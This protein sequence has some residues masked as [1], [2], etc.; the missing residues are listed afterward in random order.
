MKK[1]WRG[2]LISHI[3]RVIYHPANEASVPPFQVF[4]LKSPSRNCEYPAPGQASAGRSA[5]PLTFVGAPPTDGEENAPFATRH[6][7]SSL[8]GGGELTERRPKFRCAALLPTI[9]LPPASTFV[10]MTTLQRRLIAPALATTMNPGITNDSR[11][12]LKR[13]VP[14]T[15]NTYG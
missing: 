1:A 5:N 9:S 2:S 4:C 6:L 14:V 15:T 7:S 12:D 11:S 3:P 13:R 10:I 8:V